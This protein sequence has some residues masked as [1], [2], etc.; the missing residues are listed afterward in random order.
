MGAHLSL[1]LPILILIAAIQS[2]FVPQI[3]ILGGSPDLIMLTVLC[4][5]VDSDLSEGLTWAFVGGIVQDLLSVAPIGASAL[6][7]IL[8]V[9]IVS[10]LSRGLFRVGPI[11][12][13]ALVV[14]GT[15]LH[16]SVFAFIL[17]ATGMP[18][19]YLTTFTYVIVPSAIY[20]LA[21]VAFVYFFV[22]QAQKRLRPNKQAF[23]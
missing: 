7:L 17:A 1:S 10:L 11:L 12:L 8:I 4:W 22:R 13:S 19:S 3:R 6:G 2:S 20:N 23:S 14:T 9:F 18:S 21:A 15:V 16:Q 5:S